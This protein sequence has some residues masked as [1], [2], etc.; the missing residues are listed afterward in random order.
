MAPK[1]VSNNVGRQRRGRRARVI[2]WLT[3]VAAVA[4]GAAE[5]A[6]EDRPPEI[7]TLADSLAERVLWPGFDP[8]RTPV[9]IYDG[10]LTW[11]FRHPIPPKGFATAPEA[12]GLRRALAAQGVWTYDGRHPAV[13]ANTS[14]D[15]GGHLTAAMLATDGDTSLLQRAGTLIH[16]AFHVFQRVHHP[17]WSANEADLFTYPVDDEEVLLPARLEWEALRRALHESA[18][19]RGACWARLA[20]D[21]RNRRFAALP[22][23]ARQYERKTELNEGL[24]TYVEHEATGRVPDSDVLLVQP[25]AA[26]AVRQRG[27]RSGLAM[28][29]LLD[30]FAPGWKGRLQAES[31]LALDTLL[32]DGL[33]VESPRATC[34]F[35]A[36]ERDAAR[37]AAAEEVA[38]LTRSRLAARDAVLASPGWR[39][40]VE[41]R[42]GSPLFPQ[43]FDPLNLRVIGDGDVLH[44][45]YVKLGHEGGSI[46]VIGRSALTRAAGPHPLFNGVRTITVTG[47]EHEPVLAVAGDVVE[48]RAEGVSGR[49]EQGAVTREGTTIT[50]RLAK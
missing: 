10:Q 27:Y 20:L 39:V 40:V 6:Q 45:R 16:E 32:A 33:R 37:G 25:P 14:I 29:R 43:G 17:S 5:A 13:L 15:L 47:V 21:L 19:D 3:L 24:A 18:G 35:S 28:A 11:L 34:A 22:E 30:R 9:A 31:S 50:I 42:E 12:M 23:S 49:F 2:A 38:A 7:V 8:R 46:E 41:A 26:E 44:A 48:L 1:R 36:D 4:A